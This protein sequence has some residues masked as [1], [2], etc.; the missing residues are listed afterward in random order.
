MLSSATRGVAVGAGVTVGAGD[1]VGAV[2]HV[3]LGVVGA[4]GVESC[5]ST[6]PVNGGMLSL[7][8][9]GLLEAEAMPIT[10]VSLIMLQ[11]RAG[12]L[13]DQQKNAFIMASQARRRELLKATT[14]IKKVSLIIVLQLRAAYAA[15]L[16]K[17]EAC[18]C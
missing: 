9:R 14:P 17:V 16:A 15:I 13:L 2:D 18:I 1:V 12:A 10:K 7:L 4:I 6:R 3:G 11:L 8:S 5:E